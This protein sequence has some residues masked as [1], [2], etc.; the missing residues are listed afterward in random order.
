MKQI[1][2]EKQKKFKDPLASLRTGAGTEKQSFF[3]IAFSFFYFFTSCY[4]PYKRLYNWGCIFV[5]VKVIEYMQMQGTIITDFF[6]ASMIAGQTKH[7]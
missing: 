5:S 7:K 1:Y 3:T 6:V 4:I 2:A